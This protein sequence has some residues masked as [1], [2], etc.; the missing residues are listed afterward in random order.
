MP[1]GFTNAP[2]TFPAYID[3]CLRPSIDDSA[4][5]SLADILIYSSNKEEHEKQVQNVL[6]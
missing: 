6:E 4:V 2:A 3:N 1:F 5:C